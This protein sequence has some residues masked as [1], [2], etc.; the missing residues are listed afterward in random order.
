MSA[1][2]LLSRCAYHVSQAVDT[3]AVPYGFTLTG[4]GAILSTAARFG[5]PSQLNVWCFAVAVVATHTVL[6]LLAQ[7]LLRSAPAAWTAF[8]TALGPSRVRI[9][10]APMVTIPLCAGVANATPTATIAYPA[11]GIVCTASYVGLLC[12][13]GALGNWARRPR[14]EARQGTDSLASSSPAPQSHPTGRTPRRPVRSGGR[15]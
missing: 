12:L 2:P 11:V 14:P 8:W 1:P 15:S 3:L 6:S 13:G 9:N 5:A 4:A 7:W 10:L